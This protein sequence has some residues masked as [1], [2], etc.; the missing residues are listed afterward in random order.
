MKRMLYLLSAAAL[1]LTACHVTEPV[2]TLAV[3]PDAPVFTATFESGADTRTALDENELTVLWSASDEISIFDGDNVNH[4]YVASGAGKTADFTLKGGESVKPIGVWHALY[5]YNSETRWNGAC[6]TTALDASYTL[7]RPGTFAPGMN[8]AVARSSD[9]NLSFKNVLAWIPVGIKGASDVTKLT[10][11]GND[12]ERVSGPMDVSWEL[13]T[14]LLGTGDACKELTLLIENF[15]ES[16]SKE[17]AKYYYIPVVPG[18]FEKGFTVVVTKGD[19]EYTFSY[20]QPVTFVRGQKRALFIDIPAGGEDDKYIPLAEL[21]DGNVLQWTISPHQDI[22][23]DWTDHGILYPDTHADIAKAQWE[24]DPDAAEYPTSS[25]TYG[26]KITPFFTDGGGSKD[27]NL[28]KGCWKDHSLAFT[29]P[30]AS[31]PAG[32]SLILKFRLQ[33]GR[34]VPKGWTV[35]I[36]V[37]GAGWTAM[38]L[39]GTADDYVYQTIEEKDSEEGEPYNIV[40]PFI[41]KKGDSDPYIKASYTAETDLANADIQLRIRSITYRVAGSSATATTYYFAPQW[42]SSNVNLYILS[43]KAVDGEP[44]YPGPVIYVQ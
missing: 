40:A 37:N 2:E 42:H 3:N 4:A 1:L 27:Y 7:T 41:F 23:G 17:A 19:G 9:F 24:W 31:L 12:G 44:A 13:Q 35:E 18:T 16:P 30:V 21:T 34:W 36:N 29:V 28:V 33:A 10:F 22:N 15:E 43:V 32:K 5:P 11:K 8:I 6:F 38:A 25:D 26:N 39:T 20:D 14:E